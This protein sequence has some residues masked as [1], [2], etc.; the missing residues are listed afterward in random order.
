MAED[1][2]IDLGKYKKKA[3]APPP[4]GP[5]E[6]PLQIDLSKYKKASLQPA[7]TEKGDPSPVAGIDLKKYK[8]AE[9][10]PP[11][12][13]YGSFLTKPLS[14]SLSGTS[15]AKGYDKWIKTVVPESWAKERGDSWMG[16]FAQE[17]ARAG[18]E[19]VDFMQSPLGAGLLAAHFF[20]ATAPIAAIV[21]IGLGGIGAFESIPQVAQAFQDKS[22]ESAAA[23]V[24][25]IFMAK[26][27]L[28]GGF[29]GL[30]RSLSRFHAE[31]L[32]G[33]MAAREAASHA[34]VSETALLNAANK[35]RVDHPDAMRWQ[36]KTL[37]EIDRTRKS[38]LAEIKKLRADPDPSNEPLIKELSKQVRFL[39]DV[40]KEALPAKLAET[41]RASVADKIISPE[42]K[43]LAEFAWGGKYLKYP[44]ALL[45]VPMPRM[46]RISADIVFDK[47]VFTAERNW[48]VNN[49][50]YD[51]KKEVPIEDREVSKL[52]W[53]YQGS[54]TADEVGL[55]PAGRKW[56]KRIQEFTKEQDELERHAYGDDLP[57]QDSA[58]YLA[59]I[60]KFDKG[61]QAGI[62]TAAKKLMNDP[63]HKRRTVNS[64]RE[65]ME[66]GIEMPDGTV[67]KLEPRYNDIADILKHRADFATKAM[68]NRMMAQ[69][70]RDMGVLLSENEYRRLN[71]PGPWVRM[72]EATALYRAAYSN[73]PVGG[74]TIMK[75]V[76]VHPQFADAVKASFGEGVNIPIINGLDAVRA[77]SKK[78]F[79]SFSM[80]HHWALTEQAMAIQM[81][82]KP[83]KAP[84]QAFFLN[85]TMYKGVKSGLWDIIGREG[86][87]PPVLAAKQEVIMP[88]IKAGVNFASEERE[89]Q[90]FSV[91]RD[92]ESKNSL[93]AKGAG[94]A[95]RPLAKG[96]EAWDKGLWDFYHQGA[97]LTA[98]ETIWADEVMK[99]PANRTPAMEAHLRRTIAEHVNNAFGAI[100][101]EKM[102]ISPKMRTGMNFLLLA[103]AWTISN[104]RVLSDGYQ[105]EAGAR[106]TNKY[107]KGAAL[108]SYLAIQG[109]NMAMTGWYFKDEDRG[110]KMRPTWENPGL[111]GKIGP[112]YIDGM[113]ENALNIYAG[114]NKDGSDRYL[115][116]NK[117]F[118]EPFGWIMDPI[119]TFTGKMSQPLRTF[120]VQATKHTPGTGFAEID[121]RASFPRQMAQRA[122]SFVGT[123]GLPG[124][125]RDPANDLM[126]K[127]YPEAIPESRSSSQFMSL[128]TRKGASFERALKAYKEAVDAERWTDAARV[129]QAAAQNGVNPAKIKQQYK[130]GLRSDLKRKLGIR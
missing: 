52:G 71:P 98:L 78:T 22:P 23:A 63:F 2:G 75:P 87:K 46:T 7:K 93:I 25:A 125:I 53:V 50:L 96:L 121:D 11:S 10:K 117:G 61:D 37:G 41:Q 122:K 34:P 85:P 74:G 64:Y 17:V 97:M 6:A 94:K 59:Q 116:L 58:T 81:M 13:E 95:I 1:L 72:D 109:L 20:P 110:V 32:E 39:R 90:L 36:R 115:I 14:E 82:R 84:G 126:N 30:G 128:P 9:P 103:P 106:I 99:L 31:S 38:T 69:G 51:L 118:R 129:L 113:S 4:Q 26:G 80:F 91:I 47:A 27:M 45:G 35:H 124:V 28:K 57:L 100:N 40:H 68:G 102:L 44:A 5:P 111:P 42:A 43:K 101:W 8:Q 114:K 70:L 107:V 79:L 65:G 88:W 86:D 15:A 89:S 54:A 127:M 62:Q 119:A 16:R 3:D 49:F 24:K 112:H 108:S 55:S 130:T 83:L 12:E 48:K 92:L 77:L 66:K 19:I 33:R 120:M 60:W 18:P 123:M 73:R 29:A 21:D 76:W 104:L 56:L 67:R 105:N